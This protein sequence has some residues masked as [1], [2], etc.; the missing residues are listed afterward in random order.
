M[1]EY[2]RDKGSKEPM[3]VYSEITGDIYIAYKDELIDVTE[4]AK[5]FVKMNE[6]QEHE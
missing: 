2:D 1:S 4:S 5:Q 6:E 3:L